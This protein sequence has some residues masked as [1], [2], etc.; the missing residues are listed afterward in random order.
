MEMFVREQRDNEFS[1]GEAGANP[2]PYHWGRDQET[3]DLIGLLRVTIQQWG[4]FVSADVA[5][6]VSTDEELIAWLNSDS[7]DWDAVERSDDWS[8]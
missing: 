3:P 8:D 5:P 2:C 6:T 4:V 1:V 7:L